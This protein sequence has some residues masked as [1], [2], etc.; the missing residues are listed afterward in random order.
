MDALAAEEFGL[1]PLLPEDVERAAEL[2]GIYAD[3]PLGFV[4][5]TV[6]AMGERLELSR[7]LTT[8]RRHF[9]LIRPRHR[10][11]FHLLP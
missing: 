7:L 3:V 1:E 4:D 9:S 8:D 5:A 10:P 2:M 6:A 11:A